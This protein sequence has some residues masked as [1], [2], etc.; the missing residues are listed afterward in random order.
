MEYRRL[1]LARVTG[2]RS[3]RRVFIIATEGSRTEPLYFKMF[4]SSETTV[5]VQ[6][7]TG[8]TA[9][10]PEAVL[11]RMKQYLENNKLQRNYEAWVVVDKDAWSKE[12]LDALH[13]WAASNAHN[14]GLAVS[15]PK[16]EYWLLLHFEDGNNVANGNVCLIRLKKYL[17]NYE[18][19]NLET[20]KLRPNI[21]TAAER[22]KRRDRP[23]SP[24]W[25][26]GTGT[27]VYR[28]VEKL[29]G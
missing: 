20:A 7:V 5:T 15:N 17:P 3:Y 9:S 24:K 26:N 6:C 19:G 14:Y 21:M 16:F 10:S 4:N 13:A 18:K 27:T 11:E 28:L 23:P 8:G 29:L 1:K 12:S 25:P 22:A 2:V